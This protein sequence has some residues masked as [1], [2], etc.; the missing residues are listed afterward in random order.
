MD[1][2]GSGKS[3]VLHR[4]G[5]SG[6]KESGSAAVRVVVKRVEE[7]VKIDVDEV[8]NAFDEA[9]RRSAFINALVKPPALSSASFTPGEPDDHPACFKLALQFAFPL[10]IYVLRHPMKR[11]SSLSKAVNTYLTIMLTFLAAVCRQEQTLQ[12]FERSIP[13]NELAS[14]LVRVP[15]DVMQSHA[16]S[17][18]GPATGKAFGAVEWTM[19]TSGCSPPLDEDWCMRGMEW[20]GRRIFERG[21]WKIA[22][23]SRPEVAILDKRNPESPVMGLLR[24]T[25][26]TVLAQK[27]F[28]CQPNFS[29]MDQDSSM[30]GGTCGLC[31]RIQAYPWNQRLANPYTALSQRYPIAKHYSTCR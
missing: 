1:R 3:L 23:D 11:A 8:K 13:W 15:Q 6:S 7:E 19:L 20:V 14:F 22:E 24:M 25:R 27:G 21:Y 26:T 4:T 18:S 10:L 16:L 30:L 29:E 9:R 2:G 28:A 17:I 5:V 12:V 31:R